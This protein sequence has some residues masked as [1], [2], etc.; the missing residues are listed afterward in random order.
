MLRMVSIFSLFFALL[1]GA[2]TNTTG[3]DLNKS[4][5][6]ATNELNI[7]KNNNSLADKN[8]QKAIEA[9]K[10]FEKEQK[11]YMGDDYDLNQH[12]VDKETVEKVKEIEPEYDFD[13]TDVYAD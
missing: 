5:A 11:F 6:N 13:I 7:T 10:K 8:L 12:K 3:V 9:E 2:E 4:E 1:I